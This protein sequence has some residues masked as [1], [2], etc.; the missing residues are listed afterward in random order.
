MWP[1]FQAVG[2]KYFSLKAS[3]L[4]VTMLALC[5]ETSALT[6]DLIPA[7]GLLTSHKGK[8]TIQDNFKEKISVKPRES[9]LPSGS[10]WSTDPKANAFISLS[11]G[12]AIGIDASTRLSILEYSQR[13]FDAKK[14]GFEYEPSVSKL[15]L[16]FDSGKIAVASNRLSPL[17]NLRI[18][19][20]IGSIR[21]HKGTCIVSHDD[22]GVHLW[23]V[24]GNLTYHY[25]D[26]DSRE[27]ITA[28]NYVRI[29]EISAK[30]QQIAQQQDHLDFEPETQLLIDATK[31]SSRRVLYKANLGT[32]EAPKPVMVVRPDY[33]KQP[34]VRPYQFKD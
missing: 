22:L 11:N 5:V 23:A 33:F 4:I 19:L 16:Q 10:T 12:V 21:I 14:Q 3:F 27:F 13:P 1:T 15:Q 32:D 9:F 25:P 28:G 20:P 31:H 18:E 29:S 17:S 6:K 7:N 24:D 2:K 26:E 34:R 30:R 8:V